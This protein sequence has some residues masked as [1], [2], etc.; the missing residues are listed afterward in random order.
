MSGDKKVLICDYCSIQLELFS[1]W[2]ERC[3][4]YDTFFR[5]GLSHAVVPKQQTSLAK[6]DVIPTVDLTNEELYSKE[7][8]EMIT[9]I[10]DL[11][12]NMK[13]AFDPTTL[14]QGYECL[15]HQNENRYPAENNA[16]ESVD[17]CQS[18][19]CRVR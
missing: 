19:K 9:S 12:T 4:K 5:N 8:S 18:M 15:P 3:K 2:R 17:M 16:N 1:Q 6:K 10:N 7:K 13:T 11:L 14:L